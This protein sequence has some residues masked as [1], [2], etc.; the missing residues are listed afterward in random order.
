M[1]TTHQA[2]ASRRSARG[3]TAKN[4]H[5]GRARNRLT[6]PTSCAE[7]TGGVRQDAPI[8]RCFGLIADAY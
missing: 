8:R 1:S 3:S 2:A 5:S 7:V 6:C 4:C